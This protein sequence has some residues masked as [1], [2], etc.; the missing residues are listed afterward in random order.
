MQSTKELR[1]SVNR[2]LKVPH[3]WRRLRAVLFLVFSAGLIYSGVHI[4]RYFVE[5]AQNN[6]QLEVVR[7]AYEQALKAHTPQTESEADSTA[8]ADEAANNAY[9]TLTKLN[10]DAA[11]WLCILGTPIDHP[12]VQTDDN[13]YYLHRSFED[14]RSAHGCVFLDYRCAA[15]SRHLVLYGHRMKD[16]SMF[17]ALSQ[18]EIKDFYNAHPVISLN[19]RGEASEWQIFSVHRADDSLLPVV[20][21]DAGAFEEY[22]NGLAGLSL[23]DTGV[24][25][26]SSDTILTLSTCDGPNE[27]FVIHAKKIG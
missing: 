23:Y 7:V 1:R 18:Y 19:L 2:K 26:A 17:G 11:G 6:Q 5:N 15:D 10:A 3:A 4:V 13:D 16:G 21:T 12:F 20:F 14:A 8:P 25:A 24:K 27:R 9:L 22:M